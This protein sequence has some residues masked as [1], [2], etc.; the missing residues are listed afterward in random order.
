MIKYYLNKLIV[1]LFSNVLSKFIPLLAIPIFT[2]AFTTEEF[3]FIAYYNSVV[4]IFISIFG[5]SISTQL[6]QKYSE[7]NE[8]S[9][10]EFL[11]AAKIVTLIMGLIIF[12]CLSLFVLFTDIFEFNYI[13][14]LYFAVLGFFVGTLT[15]LK[16]TEFM[17]ADKTVE[18]LLLVNIPIILSVLYSV[19]MVKFGVLHR[20]AS[21]P[22]AILLVLVMASWLFSGRRLDWQSKPSWY[23]IGKIVSRGLALLPHSLSGSANILIERFVINSLIGTS[24][25]GLY[26]VAFS[27]AQVCDMILSAGW[28]TLVPKYFNVAQKN[29]LLEV[30]ILFGYLCFSVITSLVCLITIPPLFELMVDK[31]FYPGLTYI[32]YIIIGFGCFNVASSLLNVVIV[33]RSS[34]NI[35]M[36]SVINLLM[37]TSITIIIYKIFGQLGLGVS[38]FISNCVFL[39]I[40]SM[41]TGK[42]IWYAKSVDG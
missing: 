34:L 11:Y 1:H 16:T 17:L 31:K 42:L 7:F 32:P 23:S 5:L 36:I 21:I 39:V 28:R 8:Y 37:T 12:I 27:F 15:H 18:Y 3:G 24:A 40:V 35:N 25:L 29:S 10:H 4:M 38:F 2:A 19:I 30:R 13:F 41:F 6:L 26:F 33:R 20:I 22:L 14:I 9:K